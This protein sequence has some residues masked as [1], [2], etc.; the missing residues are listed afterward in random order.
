MVATKSHPIGHSSLATC[1]V[2]TI[3]G[4]LDRRFTWASQHAALSELDDHLLKDIGLTREDVR[5]AQPRCF[6]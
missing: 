6:D 1:V 2:R 3:L 5:R 4:W